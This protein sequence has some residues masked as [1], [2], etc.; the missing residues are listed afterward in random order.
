MPPLQSLIPFLS[1]FILISCLLFL[2]SSAGGDHYREYN[3]TNRSNNPLKTIFSFHGT[4]ALFAPAA[5][6]TLTDDNST[7]FNARPAAFGPYLPNDGLSGPVWAGKGFLEGD[8]KDIEPIATDSGE[9]G[10]DDIPGWEPNDWSLRKEDNESK[11]PWPTLGKIPLHTS[12]R[13]PPLSR[14]GTV[15][16]KED[17][18]ILESSSTTSDLKGKIALLSRGGCG[19]HEKVLWAQRRGATAVI[20]G[21]NLR[22]GPLVTMY[23][24]DD[25]SNV[26]IPS[27]FT[28][29]MTAHLLSSLVPTADNIPAQQLEATPEPIYSSTRTLYADGIHSGLWVTL[30][31][32]SMGTNPFFNT[33]FVLVISPLIT[34]AVVYVM[35]LIRGRI[36][37]R[38]WRAP[39]SVV[40]RLPV[41][42][43]RAMSTGT[44]DRF[45]VPPPPSS[46][47]PTVSTPLLINNNQS[48]SHE[49]DS[50]L[51]PGLASPQSIQGSSYGSFLSKSP[52]GEKRG[53]DIPQPRRRYAQKQSECSVCL[54]E[55]EDGVSRVMS[56]PCGHDFHA[57]CVTP[58]LT[59]K[60]RTCPICK[61][62]V[63]R[64]LSELEGVLP[65][66]PPQE[67]NLGSDIQ[68]LAA[69]TVNRSPSA[70][71]P[72]SPHH[73]DI[74]E[75][76][77]IERD[78][79]DRH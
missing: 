63:V 17:T 35:L 25:T 41:R 51:D 39:K 24:K 22:G 6:I 15:G 30:S 54:E 33:L 75:D 69:E 12:E 46:P 1:Y 71:L 13:I 57:D 7:F 65:Q 4:S 10:C 55:Y 73:D 79:R 9:L 43:Y 74:Q 27:L 61:G 52:E 78:V 36:M 58:W 34:L 37:R 18:G 31:I 53:R 29:H 14:F 44:S 32:T 2:S 40:E 26:S 20:V 45:A 23:A 21:D 16:S 72:I 68:T 48:S 77:D 50:N 28:S 59:T 60:R 8:S 47:P 67:A 19:F 11:L 3:H 70:V 62:D 56:L 66:R 38:R 64:S 49:P 5:I 42:V 76:L